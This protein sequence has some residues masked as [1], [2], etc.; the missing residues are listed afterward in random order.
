MAERPSTGNVRL[1]RLGVI[2]ACLAGG[3]LLGIST[4][5]WNLVPL[6]WVGLAILE[7]MLAED[8]P[9]PRSRSVSAGALRGLVFGAGTNLVALRF[10]VPVVTRFTPL[11]GWVGILALM[12]LSL[13]QGLRFSVAAMLTIQLAR[14]GVPRW[15]AFG[16]SVY[17]GSL[18]PCVF[19]WTVATPVAT[20][21]PLMQLAEFVGE[22][23]VAGL[24][25]LSS[26][27]AVEGLR[28]IR[29]A[30][31]SRRGGF[32]LLGAAA[33]IPV[34]MLAHGLVAIRQVEA[35]R[36]A[37]PRASVALLQPSIEATERWDPG[38]AAHILDRLTQLTRSAE[39]EVPPPDLTVWTEGAY[40]YLL[41]ARARRDVSSP[42]AIQQPGVRGPLLVGLMMRGVGGG[43][44]AAAIVSD[45]RLSQPYFKSHLLIFGEYVPL[46]DT[47]PWLNEVFYR[48]TG[49]LPGKRQVLLEAG[50]IRAVALNCYED[51]LSAAV[52]DAMS[53]DPNLI[54]NITNDAWYTG[55]MESELHLRLATT[56]T[57]EAR[58]DMVRAV[59]YGETTWVDAAGRVRAR[60]S[61][62]LPGVLRAE[63]A[64]LG[65]RTLYARAG[66]IP[67]IAAAGLAVGPFLWR[68][69]KAGRSER[70]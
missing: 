37:S 55:T 67:W 26:G 63:P 69:R 47:F 3:V 14:H 50:P 6:V 1:R 2:S 10:V 23:G 40:P 18:I 20:F 9:A 59:N 41:D 42:H 33:G 48:G 52:R 70:Q 57:I 28:A 39:S 12:L 36:L 17:L 53:L 38:E 43:Y 56:R 54:V 49:L 30:A 31:N 65:G 34:L 61:S 5:P 21:P 66:D 45:G 68:R 11:P 13:E 25:A 58:R 51:T 4:P 16:V 64:L 60:Y 24:L 15:L 7:Y 35:L 62:E 27:M 22:R 44:N 46:G 32:W 19:P 8:G 29:G